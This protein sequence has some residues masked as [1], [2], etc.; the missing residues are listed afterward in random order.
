ME[1]PTPGPGHFLPVEPTSNEPAHP[2]AAFL[3]QSRLDDTFHGGADVVY[4]PAAPDYDI[5]HTKGFAAPGN[6]KVVEPEK[7]GPSAREQ[8]D[9]W[10]SPAG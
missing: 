9:P 10:V 3:A 2:S 4:A 5:W 8:R 1:Q 6:L 7:W